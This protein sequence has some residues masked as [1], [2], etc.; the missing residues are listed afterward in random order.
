MYFQT[1]LDRFWWYFDLYFTFSEDYT[2][3]Q[4]RSQ[5]S[6][7]SASLVNQTL[8]FA[9]LDV[10]HHAGDAIHPALRMGGSGSRD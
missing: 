10:L 6:M 8:P 4:F 2:E 5:D 7:V 1:V 3:Y 9:A